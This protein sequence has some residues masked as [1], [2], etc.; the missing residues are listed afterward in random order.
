MWVLK[1]ITFRLV[2]AKFSSFHVVVAASHHALSIITG[3]GSVTPHCPA[4]KENYGDEGF[5]IFGTIYNVPKFHTQV[6][7]L[8][9]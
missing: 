9:R 8:C 1:A 6:N 7:D 2:E 4:N 3:E 5:S